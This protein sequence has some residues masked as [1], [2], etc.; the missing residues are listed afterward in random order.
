M[1]LKSQRLKEKHQEKYRA[2]NKEV[3][4]RARA[5]NRKNL[6]DVANLAKKAATRNEPSTVYKIAKLI[7]GKCHTTNML[8]RL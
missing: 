5:Y 7:R 4:H 1:D 2:A 3:K 6:N 8:F